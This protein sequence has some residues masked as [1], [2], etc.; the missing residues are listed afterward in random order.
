MKSKKEV[1]LLMTNR[2][3]KQKHVLER[4]LFE[5]ALHLILFLTYYK[6]YSSGFV[7]AYYP[8]PYILQPF[9]CFTMGKSEAVSFARRD[10]TYLRPHV[11][12]KRASAGILAAVVGSKQDF[13]VE[14][15]T[16]ARDK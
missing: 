7:S 11:F 1:I 15:G 4:E 16:H 5:K 6:S 9:Y 14:V 2:K 3:K 10:Y 12:E 8:A 13:A